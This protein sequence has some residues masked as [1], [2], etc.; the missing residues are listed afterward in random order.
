M[1]HHDPPRERLQFRLLHVFWLTTI[2]A[3]V[4]GLAVSLVS[5][6][7]FVTTVAAAPTIFLLLVAAYTTV[8]AGW[9]VIR[10]PR[11]LRRWS[12]LAERRRAV[13]LRRWQL[14][15]SVALRKGPG[16][17]PDATNMMP[18]ST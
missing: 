3:V 2:V 7:M 6:E 14:E 9:L 13:A 16:E 1:D 10:G 12:V 17:S 11:L 8:F 15:Q 18:E 4:M 5:P